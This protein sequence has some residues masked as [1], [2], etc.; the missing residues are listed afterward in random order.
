MEGPRPSGWLAPLVAGALI[1]GVWQLGV[2]LSD[3]PPSFLPSP[4]AVL[5]TLFEQRGLLWNNSLTTLLETALGVLLAVVAA[6]VWALLMDRF[7]LLRR[8]LMPYLIASQT[9]PIIVL[10]P[11]MLL[12]FG[13]GLLPKTLLVALFAFFPILL[14]TLSGLAQTPRE[15]HDLMRSLAA[16]PWQ[17]F[18][19]LRWP[20]ALPGFFAGL[21]I[22]LSYSVTGAIFAEYV[23][24]FSGLGILLQTAA[25]S[26]ATPLVFA[27]VVVIALLSSLLVA[28][29]RLLERV[30][31]P[32]R[33]Q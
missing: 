13:F 28:C 11:L 2:S 3:L 30:L 18:R 20:S 32:W 23:G 33:F 4:L 22:T 26:R 17:T 1:L 29:V 8:A 21:R 31:T 10:A 16:T 12:W 14:S 5:T 25:N 19:L 27:T 6:L 15:R 7:G 24:S 9:V